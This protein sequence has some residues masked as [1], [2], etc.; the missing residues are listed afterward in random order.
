MTVGIYKS[1]SDDFIIEFNYFIGSTASIPSDIQE[2]VVIGTH[3]LDSIYYKDITDAAL[4][5]GENETSEVIYVVTDIGKEYWILYG[6][7]KNTEH[8]ENNYDHIKS[9]YISQKIGEI[10]NTAKNQLK[11]SLTETDAYK[12][13]KHSDISM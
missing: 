3:S 13:L 7:D 10:I 8:F 4:S 9:V 6:R 1:R 11:D 5:L 2:G 12:N